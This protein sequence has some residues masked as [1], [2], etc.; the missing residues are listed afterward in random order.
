MDEFLKRFEFAPEFLPRKASLRQQQADRVVAR[1]ECH[2]E[3]KENLSP[4]FEFSNALKLDEQNV[5]GN[6]GLGKT[7]LATGQPDNAANIFRKFSTIEAMLEP[8]NKHIFN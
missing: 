6:F 5:R 1:A 7:Y 8:E 2:R 3:A 4:E